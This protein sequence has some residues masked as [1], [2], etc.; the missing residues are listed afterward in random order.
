MS[1]YGGVVNKTECAK[2]ATC[3]KPGD[4]CVE[5]GMGVS[6]LIIHDLMIEAYCAGSEKLCQNTDVV[7]GTTVMLVKVNRNRLPINQQ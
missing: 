4:W 1:I 7:C 2:T 5:S 6:Y 3:V